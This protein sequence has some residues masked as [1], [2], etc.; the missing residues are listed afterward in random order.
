MQ[1]E[2]TMVDRLQ[3]EGEGELIVH[4]RLDLGVAGHGADHSWRRVSL[5]AVAVGESPTST[6]CKSYNR[7]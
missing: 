7:R 3:A 1:V 4:V 6:N 2:K 5:S